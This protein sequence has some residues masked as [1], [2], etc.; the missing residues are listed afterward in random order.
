MKPTWNINFINTAV[1]VSQSIKY[2]TFV[3]A[4]KHLVGNIN[5]L[6]KKLTTKKRIY[7]QQYN[8]RIDYTTGCV[9]LLVGLNLILR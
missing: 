2:Y 6:N 4:S 8:M 3:Y 1:V 7:V 5:K 9:Y